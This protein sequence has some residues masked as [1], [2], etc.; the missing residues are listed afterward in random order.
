MTTALDEFYKVVKQMRLTH[1]E[2]GVLQMQY[3]RI[4]DKYAETKDEPGAEDTEQVA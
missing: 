4:R 3:V 1:Q 2:H